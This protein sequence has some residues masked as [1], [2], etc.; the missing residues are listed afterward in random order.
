[1]TKHR[2]SSRGRRFVEKYTQMHRL[3]EDEY[4]AIVLYIGAENWPFPTPLVASDGK[5]YFDAAAGMQ[6]VLLRRI[7][8][9]E[10]HVL[11]VCHAHVIAPSAARQTSSDDRTEIAGL[12]VNVGKGGPAVA[13]HGYYFRRLDSGEKITSSAATTPFAFIAYPAE[14][15][16]TGVM[17]FLVDRDGNVYEKDLGPNT[18]VMAKA[19]SKQPPHDT[20]WR[21]VD[22]ADPAG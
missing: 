13:F 6:E 10:L 14:Y 12:L 2:T 18:A 7:G 19:M 21:R 8:E 9:N 22:D 20:T 4:G 5:W 16:S 17:T 1:M 15:R 3:V 11:H